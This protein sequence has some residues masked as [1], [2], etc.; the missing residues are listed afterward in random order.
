MRRKDREITAPEAMDAIISRCD[1][2]RIALWDEEARVPYIVPLNF[3]Y[4]REKGEPV[5]F[6]HSAAAGRK[7][8]LLRKSPRVAFELDTAHR[9]VHDPAGDETT[10]LYES[11][12]GEGT[13]TFLEDPADPQSEIR[14]YIYIL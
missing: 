12:M 14:Q 2:C 9:L 1:C 6:F 13:V 5:F 7:I 10:M 8:D 3:G 11:V 4:C